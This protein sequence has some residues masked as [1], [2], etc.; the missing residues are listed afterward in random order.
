MLLD[1]K[2][3]AADA[4][5]AYLDTLDR[6]CEWE[7]VVDCSDNLTKFLD[8]DIGE[9]SKIFIANLAKVSLD[10]NRASADAIVKRDKLV[11]EYALA[12]IGGQLGD[13]IDYEDFCG[14]KRAIVVEEADMNGDNIAVSGTRFL[15]SGRAGI[16]KDYVFL[17]T[18]SW[19]RRT[20]KG[21]KS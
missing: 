14:R 12:K 5:Q 18:Y 17:D 3:K 8:L 10:L 1:L 13:V 11:L 19:Q 21:R 4:E 6:V 7:D 15:Q 2:K 16:R 9:E 20:H